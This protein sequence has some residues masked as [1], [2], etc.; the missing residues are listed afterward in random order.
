LIA[1][2][3]LELNDNQGIAVLTFLTIRDTKTDKLREKGV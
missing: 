1:L 3:S 2:S